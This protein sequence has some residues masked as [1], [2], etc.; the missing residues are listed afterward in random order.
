[1]STLKL[2]NVQLNPHWWISCIAFYLIFL[3]KILVP[4]SL[5]PFEHLFL[6][7]VGGIVL[8]HQ[9]GKDGFKQFMQK[10][11]V[12][13][14]LWIPITIVACLII[15]TLTSFIGKTLG[16]THTMANQGV[17]SIAQSG[18]IST[19]ILFF[20]FGWLHL[21]GE[22]L[23]TAIICLPLL[24]I[25]LKKCSRNLA[26]FISISVSTIVF[27]AIHLPAYGWDFYQA[28]IVIGLVRLPFT[29]MWFKSKSIWGGAIPHA[30]FDYL[31]VILAI[32][33]K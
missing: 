6:P 4:I 25:L 22:E 20:L 30:I 3:I 33:G 10:P 27:G 24:V 14:L 8:W 7:I 16:L 5:G 28:I 19:K 21:L 31:I 17:E 15:G 18:N 2:D 11:K 26:L 12:N 23:M 29:F 1:M 32:L 13:M 9:F